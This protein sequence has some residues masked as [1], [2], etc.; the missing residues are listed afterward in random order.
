MSMPVTILQW[1]RLEKN[2]LMGFAKI[3]IGALIISD[4]TV[5]ASNGRKWAGL[6]SKPMINRDGQVMQDDRGKTR[7]SPIL[8]WA[9][10]ETADRFSKAVISAIEAEHPADT[11]PTPF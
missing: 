11:D 9:S 5:M 4:V 6:P 1:R 2:N 7:Y 8:E 10:K 3:Q